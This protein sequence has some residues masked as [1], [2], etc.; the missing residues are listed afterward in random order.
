VIVTAFALHHGATT[1]GLWAAGAFCV[2][3]LQAPGTLLAEHFRARK[4]ITVLAT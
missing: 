1:I 3:L 4:P 2:Q